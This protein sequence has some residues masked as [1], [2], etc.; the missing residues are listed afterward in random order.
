MEKPALPENETERLRT[1]R[2]L[3]ILDTLPEERFD[4]LT[5][6]AKRLFN[7]PIALVSLVDENRQWFKSSQGLDATETGRD[8]SFCGHSIL[9]NQIF[10]I[11]DA[12]KD[13]RFA[14]NPLVVD[15]PNIRFYAGC[16]LKTRNANMGTLCIIDEKPRDFVED[17]LQALADLAAMVEQELEAVQLATL[18]ELT[19][20][21]NRRGFKV[22]A[23]HS[24]NLCLR[25][26]HPASLIYIDL[27]QFKP[28]NDTF[29]HAEG[30]RALMAF[31]DLLKATFRN[32]D[33]IARLGGDEFVVL[34]TNTSQKNALEKVGQ[35]SGLLEKNNREKNRGY[36]LSF[37]YGIVELDPNRHQSV[38][39]L[40]SDGD[41]MMYSEKKKRASLTAS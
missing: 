17:D 24:L 35:F 7:V 1:L 10:I 8:I 20:I 16:P 22:L 30:D 33:I 38:D 5:R 3:N 32:S 29:G 26:K 4:R 39:E 40:L 15:N 25:Q 21:S 28:I 31:A 14:D 13:E 41:A 34:L 9:G 6:M 36:D 12:S 2:S 11:Q 37:S 19:K 27:N 23:Q 18:D